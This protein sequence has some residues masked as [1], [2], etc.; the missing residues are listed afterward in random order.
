M[1]PGIVPPM[2]APV[3]TGSPVIVQ[4]IKCSLV[5]V[6]WISCALCTEVLSNQTYLL[7]V[8]K[9]MISQSAHQSV[10]QSVSRWTKILKVNHCMAPNTHCKSLSTC[11]W[12]YLKWIY[13][14]YAFPGVSLFTGL[15]YWTGLL[16][17]FFLQ[18]KIILWLLKIILRPVIRLTCL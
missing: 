5:S 4:I 14:V 16:D 10:N 18:L 15:E 7:Q 13:F 2:T 3:S 12:K 9:C 17:W 8:Y 1:K 11:T 6:W